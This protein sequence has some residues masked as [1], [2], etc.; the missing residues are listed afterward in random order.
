MKV[1]TL[2]LLVGASN[3][4]FGFKDWM[5]NIPGNTLISQLTIPGTHNSYARYGSNAFAA[6]YAICQ[7]WTIQE[8]LANGV[9]FFDVRFR[10]YKHYFTIHHGDVYQKKVGGDVFKDFKNFLKNNPTE[11]VL[12]SYKDETR[13]NS[14]ISPFPNSDSFK[15]ILKSYV[16]DGKYKPWIHQDY[17]KMPT[18]EEVRGKMFFIDK[19]GHGGWG[20]GNA[21]IKDQWNNIYHTVVEQSG[22]P[23]YQLVETDRYITPSKVNGIKSH[24]LQAGKQKDLYMTFCSG[25]DVPRNSNKAIANTINPQIQSFIREKDQTSNTFGVV[26]F[27]FPSVNIINSLTQYNP[28]MKKICAT[29]ENEDKDNKWTIYEKQKEYW[30]GDYWNDNIGY[31]HLNRGCY[32]VAYDDMQYEGTKNYLLHKKDRNI[33]SKDNDDYEIDNDGWIGHWW[34]NDISS[35]K[36]YC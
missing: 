7:D 12:I 31:V 20:Y 9:R 8:Q 29:L 35:F 10:P 11:T 17:S 16:N 18:L 25:S 3:C 36:C 19:N 34:S 28:G 6:P 21:N 15:K 30:L 1:I 22:P 32:L 24:M 26:I 5:R 33:I 2:L 4:A 23:S 13:G 14:R 27:D